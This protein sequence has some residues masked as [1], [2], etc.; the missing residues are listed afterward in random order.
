MLKKGGK[1]QYVE[2]DC[3]NIHKILIFS[4]IFLNERADGESRLLSC[5]L[6]GNIV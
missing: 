1:W 3:A 5:F 6:S 4:F 2:L